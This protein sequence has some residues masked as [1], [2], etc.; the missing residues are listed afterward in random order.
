MQKLITFRDN[1]GLITHMHSSL[2]HPRLM[3]FL[4]ECLYFV[5]GE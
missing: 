1:T 4:L 3:P 2:D 5:K